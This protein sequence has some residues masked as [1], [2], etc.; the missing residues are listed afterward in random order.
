MYELKLQGTD[1]AVPADPAQS[2]LDA[3]LAQDLAMPYNCRSGECG[4]C[5]AR[6][7][8]GQVHELPGADP[9][10]YTEQHRADGFV[11]AC[12]CYPR[13]DLVIDVPLRTQAAPHIQ[14]FDAIV[15]RVTW[16]GPRTAHVVVRC[17]Q[18]IDFRGGQ[19]F[20]WTPYGATRP[21]SYSAAN[22]PGTERLEF[23]V[24][25]YPDGQVSALLKRMELAAGDILGLRGP[26]GTYQFETVS[27]V[28]ALFVAGGTGL[29]PV[30]S[31]VQEALAAAPKGGTRPLHVYYGARDREEAACAQP[32]LDLAAAHPALQVVCA[33]SDEPADSPWTGLRGLVVDVLRERIGDQFGSQAYLCGPPGLVDA[34]TAVL[35]Q[36]GVMPQDIHCDKFVPAH[37]TGAA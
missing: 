26:F 25:L 2:V 36:R 16:F 24:R 30:L 8:S 37:D 29:A 14:T 21:R 13:S 28:P 32:L 35:Q 18:P 6:L 9:A 19:Y 17:P 12:L 11:L 1:T 10:V 3:C 23:L 7:V 15:E 22:A 20:E 27:P 33:L 4:E 31:I 34:A 5:M